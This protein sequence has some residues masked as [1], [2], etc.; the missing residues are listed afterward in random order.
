MLNSYWYVFKAVADPM[1]MW[2]KHGGLVYDITHASQ[3]MH[4][5]VIPLPFT[6][7]TILKSSTSR[8]NVDVFLDYIRISNVEIDDILQPTTVKWSDGRSRGTINLITGS[9]QAFGTID[10]QRAYSKYH[11]R[12]L[13]Q[14]YSKRYAIKFET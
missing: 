8:G 5:K 10:L 2:L 4:N 7:L 9:N 12:D 11:S 14:S 1:Q 6:T 13:R 3:F